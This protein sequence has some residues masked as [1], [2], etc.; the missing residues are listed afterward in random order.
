METIH[1]VHT[2]PQGVARMHVVANIRGKK[3]NIYVG[4]EMCLWMWITEELRNFFAIRSEHYR[5]GQH[6]IDTE[7]YGGDIGWVQ[8][9]VPESPEREVF[10]RM[11]SHRKTII[12]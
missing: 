6:V 2:A 8:T 12:K 10:I 1:D 11:L 4:A 9:F 5:L 7:K 3:I